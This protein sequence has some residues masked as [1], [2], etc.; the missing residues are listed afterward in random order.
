VPQEF[1]AALQRVKKH[2]PAVNNVGALIERPKC[3]EYFSVK[4]LEVLYFFDTSHTNQAAFNGRSMIA[5]TN[6]IG[7]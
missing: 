6:P 2:K 5:P 7:I 3:D 4:S 1:P